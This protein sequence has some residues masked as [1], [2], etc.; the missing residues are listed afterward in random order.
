M[1]QCGI[2]HMK[3]TYSVSDAAKVLDVD[4]RTL[5]RWVKKKEIPAPA[6]RIVEGRLVKSWT[7]EEMVQLRRYKSDH[8]YGKGLDRR[9]GRKAKQTKQQKK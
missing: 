5:Q 9:T 6:A 1:P 2:I 3:T 8:Y 7:E 4:R